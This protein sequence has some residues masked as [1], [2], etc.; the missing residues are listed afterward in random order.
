[1]VLLGMYCAGLLASACTVFASTEVFEDAVA[2]HEVHSL[3]QVLHVVEHEGMA[4][5][6]RSR[7]G[8]Q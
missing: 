5:E 8:M 4:L 1:M 2:V 3:V 6:L 7:A